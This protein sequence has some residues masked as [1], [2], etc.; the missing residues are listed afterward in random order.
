MR[1]LQVNLHPSRAASAALCVAMKTV[2]VALAQ[3]PWTYKGAI[4]GLKEV[5]GE[6]IYSGSTLTSRTCT[7]I[8][9]GFQILPL[10]NHNSRHLTAVTIKTSIDGGPRGIILASAYLP[11][12]NSELRH[13]W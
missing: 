8:K 7:L 4:R 1:V 5:G 10:I 12:D 13:P 6:L 11:Y 3:E 2:D 9:R